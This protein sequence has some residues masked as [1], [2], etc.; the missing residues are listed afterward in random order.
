MNH[1]LDNDETDLFLAYDAQSEL[2]VMNPK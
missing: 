2:L 1:E